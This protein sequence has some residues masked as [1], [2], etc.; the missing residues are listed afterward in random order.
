MAEGVE[1]GAETAVFNPDDQ[2]FMLPGDH[3]T[4]IQTICRENDFAIPQTKGE[5]VHCVLKSLANTYRDVLQ[6][7][8]RLSDKQID[9]L[10]IVGGGTQNQLLNQLTADSMGIP[11]IT[12][13]IEA[14]VIGNAMVQLITLGEIAD[15]NEGRQLVQASFKMQRYEPNIPTA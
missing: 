14:T 10:H 9:V 8:A 15:T 1:V 4:L 6:Q 5:I 3:P 7:L 2:R 11:V 13:P 12:G